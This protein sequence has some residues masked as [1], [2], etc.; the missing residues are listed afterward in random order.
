MSPLMPATPTKA[1]VFDGASPKLTFVMGVVVGI[2]VISLAGF[3]LAGSYVL[4]GGSWAKLATPSAPAPSATTPSAQPPTAPSKVSIALKSTDHVRG[5]T[6][7]PVTL[8]AYT[9]LECPY[10]KR[11]HP[12]VLQALQEYGSKLRVVYRNFPLSFHA[13]AQ[14]EAE[15]AECVAKIGGNNAYWSF[16]DKI[17]ERTTSNGTGFAL[18]ALGPLAKEVGVSQSRFQTCLDQGEMASRVQTDLTE[19]SGYGVNGTPT[20]FINGTPLEGAVPFEQLKAV[21]DQV[22]QAA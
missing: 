20:S 6:N 13:N 15:A 18:T 22:L 12:V 10:C 4:S 7:A 21:I 1:S 16:V 3:V 11:F 8:V 9:D 17:F 14:K 2:A 19:G 5:A